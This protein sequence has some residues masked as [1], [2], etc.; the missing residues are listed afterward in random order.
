MLWRREKF[1][2]IHKLFLGQ[3]TGWFRN[4]W[5]STDRIHFKNLND[6]QKESKRSKEKD[7]VFLE[8]KEAESKEQ[9]KVII[10]TL[11]EAAPTWVS[12]QINFVVGNRGS[13]VESNFYT[14]LKKLDVQE[15]QKNRLF[16]DH[17]TQVY[18]AHD[19]VI[20]SILQQVQGFCE[21]KHN[22]SRD[23]NRA[24]CSCVNGCI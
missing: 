16:V 12:E 11:R 4:Q 24:Q 18:A 7:E 9:H 5:G 6:Q 21:A 14:N 13:V 2:K 23:D 15:G 3:A 8:L 19:R 10:S 1:L 20:L 17:V 22:E